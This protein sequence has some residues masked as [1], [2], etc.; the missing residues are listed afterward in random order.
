MNTLI[1]DYPP[2]PALRE[3]IRNYQI[4]RWAFSGNALPPPKLLAPRP[5]HSLA[6]YIRDKQSFTYL[7][8]TRP[9]VYPQTILSG[10]HTVTINRDCGHDFL[11]LKVVLQPCALYR[12]TGIPA[13]ELTS[14]FVDAEAIWG[15]AI[16]PIFEQLANADTLATMLAVVEQ[17]M[18]G[19]IQRTTRN[20][21]PVDRASQLMLTSPSASSLD[22]LARQSGLSIRQFIRKFDERTGVSPKLFDRITRF[23]RVY[24]LKNSQPN[25]D[26]LSIA[27]SCGYYDYQH[28]AKDY[29]DFTATTP[30]SFYETDKKA[31]ERSFGLYFG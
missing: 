28:L 22:W 4:I 7:D 25:L 19:L 29:K 23:N 20:E 26:W 1:Q 2:H 15:K 14:S 6:F 21:H 30:V 12:L 13:A 27:L 17:F 24:R 3:F 16:R 5:E 31:P 9:I 10:I 8:S 18:I 11:V